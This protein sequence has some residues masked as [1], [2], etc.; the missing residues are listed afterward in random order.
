MANILSGKSVIEAARYGG[1]IKQGDKVYTMSDNY[2]IFNPDGTVKQFINRG[3]IGTVL[4]IVENPALPFAGMPGILLYIKERNG[5][6][7]WDENISIY[8]STPFKEVV[9]DT[10]QKVGDWAGDLFK[11]VGSGLTNASIVI[12]WLPFVALVIGVILIY[13]FTTQ[14]RFV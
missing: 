5:V 13:Y 9:P 12:K 11:N 8:P 6:A 3:E 7:M 4:Y 2:P 14:K 1:T 10:L